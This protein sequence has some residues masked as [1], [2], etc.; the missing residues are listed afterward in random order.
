MRSGLGY[1][2]GA[3]ILVSEYRSSISH[4]WNDL[5]RICWTDLRAAAR[6]NLLFRVSRSGVDSSN[7]LVGFGSD[8]RTNSRRHC[9]PRCGGI[10]SLAYSTWDTALV[11]TAEDCSLVFCDLGFVCPVLFR[12]LLDFKRFS[13]NPYRVC[14]VSCR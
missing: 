8:T 3:D 5:N 1:I 13:A 7:W 10:L 4:S 11:G 6:P 12:G 2:Y 9:R 14:C